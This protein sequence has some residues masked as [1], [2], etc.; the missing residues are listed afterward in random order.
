MARAQGEGPGVNM[1][2]GPGSPASTPPGC[3]QWA[4]SPPGPPRTS[5]GGSVH[6]EAPL[7]APGTGG[8]E[9]TKRAALRG[10]PQLTGAETQGSS[11][12]RPL[13]PLPGLCLWLSDNKMCL[14]SHGPWSGF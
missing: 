6:P 2:T 11:S 12:L 3:G 10:E 1:S 5:A 8:S 7:Q 14:S 9:D 13:L 4:S